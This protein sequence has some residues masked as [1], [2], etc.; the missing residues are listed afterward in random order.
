MIFPKKAGVI[1]TNPGYIAVS[2]AYVSELIS[3]NYTQ[4]M[5]FTNPDTPAVRDVAM[6]TD[7]LFDG[8]KRWRWEVR[9]HTPY[10]VSARGDTFL[11]VYEIFSKNTLARLYGMTTGYRPVTTDT[12]YYTQVVDTSMW[13]M[14]STTTGIGIVN[15]WVLNI[16]P[17]TQNIIGYNATNLVSVDTKAPT[18]NLISSQ[19]LRPVVDGVI[20]TATWGGFLSASTSGALLIFNSNTTTAKPNTRMSLEYEFRIS[21]GSG[22]SV[23]DEVES[24]LPGYKKSAIAVAVVFGV[25]AVCLVI[26]FA[27]YFFCLGAWLP[28]WAVISRPGRFLFRKVHDWRRPPAPRFRADEDDEDD[29]DEHDPLHSERVGADDI[30]KMTGGAVGNAAAAGK[31]DKHHGRQSSQDNVLIRLRKAMGRRLSNFVGWDGP[32]GAAPGIAASGSEK[33]SSSKKNKNKN[34]T[35]ALDSS[36][37]TEDEDLDTSSASYYAQPSHTHEESGLMGG[38]SDDG[39]PAH[40]QLGYSSGEELDQSGQYSPNS[41]PSSSRPET[42]VRMRPD[43]RTEEISPS[44]GKR[45]AAHPTGLRGFKI[46]S[47]PAVSI[48]QPSPPPSAHP[49]PLDSPLTSP[50]GSSSAPN[51]PE[52]ERK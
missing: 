48:D 22:S 29:E 50:T 41:S 24:R 7:T 23:P 16:K 15:Q 31:L 51:S 12:V 2:V 17:G 40:L 45:G 25:P 18:M 26:G 4:F 19:S 38:D 3:N 13:S 39:A 21:P 30:L 44:R 47:S 1:P 42:P 46:T 10:T 34:K 8:S 32:D 27:T 43:A 5:D 35:A 20:G 11:E 36:Q 28:I 33:A 37:V 49:V 52:Q 9:S 14:A 6:A